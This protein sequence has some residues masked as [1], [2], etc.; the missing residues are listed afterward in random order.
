M[1]IVEA[2]S[3]LIGAGGLAFGGYQYYQTRE[4]E[5]RETDLNNYQIN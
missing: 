4:A 1:V 3:I 5:Q 2:A